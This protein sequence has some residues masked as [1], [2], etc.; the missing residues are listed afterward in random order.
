M[1]FIVYPSDVVA[2]A[3]PGVLD[4][5]TSVDQ[6]KAH[7]FD[8]L[9]RLGPIVPLD[10]HDSVADLTAL[11]AQPGTVLAYVHADRSSPI[12]ARLQ[13]VP[14]R[15]LWHS[16]GGL[17]LPDRVATL[18]ARG[19]AGV[20]LVMTPF[21]RDR[22]THY[23]GAA[24]QGLG[25]VPYPIDR[26]YWRP[27]TPLERSHARA[28][29]GVSGST[30][31][32]VYA[33]RFL[34]TKGICQVVQA[35]ETWPMPDVRLTLAGSVE[36]AFPIR[37]LSGDHRGFP[38]YVAG[39]WQTQ[40]ASCLSVLPSLDAEGLRRLCWSADAFICPSWH[41]DENY[42]I[43]PRQAALCGVPPV[44]TDFAGL[45]D[46]ARQL[47]WGGVPTYPTAVGVRFSLRDL[48]ACIGAALDY[49][50]D[51]SWV[52]RVRATCD[53]TAASAGLGAA[54]ASLLARAPQPPVPAD[55]QPRAAFRRLFEHADPLLI[56]AITARSA[57]AP[58]GLFAPGTGPHNPDFP[59]NEFFA[60]IQ[61]MYTTAPRPPAVV[62]GSS[63]RGFFPCVLDVERRAVVEDGYPGPRVWP[64]GDEWTAIEASVDGG[65]A[66]LRLT[67]RTPTQ[68]AAVQSL[69]H[70]GMLV[71]DDPVSV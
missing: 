38:A 33:G 12:H 36:P 50:G 24:V 2:V 11:F 22:L 68:C 54:V 49:D 3:A 5:S 55:D 29:L 66:S 41:E 60:A 65:S 15:S 51:T 37:A 9:R 14:Q 1:R 46:L 25:V 13:A 52:D 16:L 67:P 61:R 53:D 62:G 17:M 19:A 20:T 56:A 47:P 43:T 34:V 7:F 28:E 39:H 32:L 57:S 69:V 21:Q 23:L 4:R 64:L 59:R 44:V 27:P 45:A 58:D 10:E 40:G 71:P 8:R 6:V 63:W 31:H 42:G 30:T 26:E 48:R 18:T 70:A 35:L